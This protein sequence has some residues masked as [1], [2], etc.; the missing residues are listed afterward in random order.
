MIS[1]WF[2]WISFAICILLLSKVIGR[3]SNNKKL[4]QILRNV[5]KP[6]GIT[7]IIIGLIHGLL[8]ITDN[9]ELNIQI[10]T[11]TILWIFIIALA[12][13]FYARVKLKT[14]W[15]QM[16]RHLSIVLVILMIIHI[17]VSV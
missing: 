1:H 5:H 13:T 7:I 14:K 4:N 10:I 6:L 17:I 11:G 3:I 15:F 8:C 2:G 9:F 12:R 16:H